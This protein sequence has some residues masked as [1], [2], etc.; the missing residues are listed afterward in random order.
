MRLTPSLWTTDLP[1]SGII[2]PGAWLFILKINIDSSGCP[3]TILYFKLP[4]PFPAA[5]GGLK[6]PCFLKS[7][8]LK[9]RSSPEFF[10]LPLGLW[11]CAQLMSR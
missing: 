11:Q 2:T 7:L 4:D 9:L 6:I 5:T 1:I 10:A 8:W 3:G